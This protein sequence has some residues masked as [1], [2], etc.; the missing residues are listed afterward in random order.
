LLDEP[1]GALDRK[2]RQH[3]QIELKQLQRKLGTTFIFV[4]HD[5]E[6]AL[7]LSDRVAVMRDGRIEQLDS[8]S[9]LYDN[10]CSAFVA[11][12]IGQNNFLS[13][14]NAAIRPEHVR[15]VRSNTSPASDAIRGR[16]TAAVMLGEMMQYVLTSE[17]G[18][19]EIIVRSP[20]HHGEARQE[21]DD[22]WAVW[23]ARDVR[24]F[25]R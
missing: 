2:L 21:G 22:C 24:T 17:D 23:D 12:F 15:L 20:R 19:E 25:S 16:I 3:V 9:V 18:Q 14:R 5:Q 1:L 7:A 8:P 11:G 13:G 10:P 6:E 4:T